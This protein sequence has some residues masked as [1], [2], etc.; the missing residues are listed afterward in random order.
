MNY[1]HVTIE[2]AS[3]ILKISQ[4]LIWEQLIK[5]DKLR[6]MFFSE[7]KNQYFYTDQGAY[8]FFYEQDD[9]HTDVIYLYQKDT[10]HNYIRVSE[11]SWDN[12]KKKKLRFNIEDVTNLGITHESRGLSCPGNFTPNEDFTVIEFNDKEYCFSDNQGKAIKYLYDRWRKGLGAAHN[13]DIFQKANIAYEDKTLPRLFKTNKE[14][15]KKIIKFH[16]R[17]LYSINL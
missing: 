10:N 2:D 11:D 15:F 17:G 1:K 5:V 14:D 7:S 8:D 6:P 9:N 16:K 4:E 12:V 3:R 13:S